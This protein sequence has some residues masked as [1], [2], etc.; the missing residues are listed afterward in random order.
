MKQLM[1]YVTASSY[2]LLKNE[3]VSM[4]S[5]ISKIVWYEE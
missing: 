5:C 1:N 2:K 3:L 4:A